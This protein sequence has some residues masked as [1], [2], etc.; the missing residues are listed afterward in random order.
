LT[1]TTGNEKSHAAGN[2]KAMLRNM[3]L[4]NLLIYLSALFFAGWS[5]KDLSRAFGNDDSTNITE[6]CVLANYP[7]TLCEARRVK[8]S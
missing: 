8:Y 1:R 5:R 2:E 7:D 3:A 6:C 4:S